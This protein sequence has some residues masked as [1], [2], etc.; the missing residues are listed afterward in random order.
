[1][2]RREPGQKGYFM[3]DNCLRKKPRKSKQRPRKIPERHYYFVAD[4][5]IR[6]ELSKFTIIIFSPVTLTAAFLADFPHLPRLSAACR[7]GNP[8]ERA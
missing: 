2:P 6:S 7:R 3:M 4:G 1:M 5:Q 8:R